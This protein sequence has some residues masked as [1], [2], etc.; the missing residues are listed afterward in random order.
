MINNETNS[1]SHQW[2]S[3]AECSALRGIAILA[4]VLHNYCHWLGVAVKENEYTFSESNN[5]GI[6]RALQY[7]DTCLPVHLLSFFGHYG[8]PV[9]LFLSGYGL[10]MKYER[11]ISLPVWGFIR[12]HYLKLFRM[13]IVGFVAFIIIDAIT[14]GAWH[15]HADNVIAQLLMYINLLPTPDRVIW[16][17]PYWFFGLM[18]QFYIVYRLL[19]YHRHWAFTVGAIVVCSLLQMLCMPESE[20]LN[21]LRYNCIGG[22]LV[23]GAGLLLARQ[24]PSQLLSYINRW[25]WVL[26]GVASVLLLFVVCFDYYSWFFAPL[27]IIAASIGVVKILP[28]RML[29]ILVWFGGISAAMFVAHPVLRK[30]FI[31]ISRQGDIYDGLLLYIIATIA[32]S[33]MFKLII[34]KLPSP[35]L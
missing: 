6:M 27:L 5:L 33:W 17:G 8:V 18:L 25:Q 35:K 7:P 21:R 4:I 23:F 24:R 13:M 30:I 20:T 9:F 28:Q 14:P 11:Q 10:I 32:V 12:Y 2:L 16:P 19:L 31:P 22:M 3:R 26:I 29:D 1:G 34:N 15:F